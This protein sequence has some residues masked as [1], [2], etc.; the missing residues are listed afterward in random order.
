MGEATGEEDEALVHQ[1]LS[2]HPLLE[3]GQPSR[4][5]KDTLLGKFGPKVF[6]NVSSFS[7]ILK[8]RN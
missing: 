8:P 5:G 7:L 4:E 3:A 2:V 6:F 1:I